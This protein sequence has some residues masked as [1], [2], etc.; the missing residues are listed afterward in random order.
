MARKTS[1]ASA[2]W[3]TSRGCTNEV[4]SIH[5]KPAAVSMSTKRIFASVGMRA[6]SFC[7]PSRGPTSTTRTSMLNILR[8]VQHQQACSSHDL[9]ADLDAHCPDAASMRRLN[10]VLHLHR[11]EHHQ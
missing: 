11:L 2:N 5:P 4:T 8:R 6:G 1:S 10:H 7:K 9:L 3:G